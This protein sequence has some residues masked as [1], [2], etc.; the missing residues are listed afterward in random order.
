MT[1]EQILELLPKLLMF[2]LIPAIIFGVVRFA[3]LEYRLHKNSIAPV[4]TERATVYFKHPETDAPYLGRGY[5]YVHY[6]TFHTDR[7]EAVKL[8]MNRYDF[9]PLQEGSTGALT[10]QGEKFWK[11]EQEE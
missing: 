5:S 9:Y 1:T 8:Y 4:H 10:W 6:V 11:F 2:T 3:V 7:G